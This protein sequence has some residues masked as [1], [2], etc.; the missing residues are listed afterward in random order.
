MKKFVVYTVVVGGYDEI[1]QPL[2]IDDRFD[3]VLFTDNKWDEKIGVWNVRTFDYK[4]SKKNYESRY[5]KM[6]PTELL[7]EYEASLYIDGKIQI[8][9]EYVYDKSVSFFN[10][11]IDWGYVNV[12]ERNDIY[13]EGLYVIRRDLDEIKKVVKWNHILQRKHYPR[14]NG[15]TDNCV[16]FRIHNEK[17]ADA[18]ALWWRLFERFVCRDQ[19]LLPYVFWKMPDLEKGCLSPKDRGGYPWMGSSMQWYPHSVRKPLK[20]LKSSFLYALNRTYNESSNRQGLDNSFF[21][22]CKLQPYVGRYVFVLWAFMVIAIYGSYAKYRTWLRH[23]KMM[24]K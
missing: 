8:C 20:S 1:H 23:K 3:Y 4:N 21:K 24:R 12:P 2:V 19:A 16:I 17:V 14:Y 22:I 13:S 9:G 15:L 7:P 10:D 6:H 18:N 11:G 5:P